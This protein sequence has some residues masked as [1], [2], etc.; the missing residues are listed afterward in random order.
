M[1]APA[2]G[3]GMRRFFAPSNLRPMPFQR[4]MLESM[5]K[6][7]AYRRIEKLRQTINHHRY[8]YHVEDREEISPAAL[9]SLKHELAE[10]EAEFP[11]LV[12]PDSPTQRVAGEPLPEFQKIRHAVRQWSFNDIFNEQELRDFDERM[13]RMLSEHFGKTVRPSYVCELKIDGL[14][15]V[16]TYEAGLLKTAATRGDGITGE[17]VTH[18]VRTIESVPLV[19]ERQ[20][21]CVVEG[22]VW[23]SKKEL[24]RI[25]G[26]REKTAEPPFANP[27][28]AAAGSIR[29]LDARI[30][31]SRKL[32]MFIYDL[33]AFEGVL[34]ETQH[35]ELAF[36]GELGFKTN[37]H[38]R[39]VASVDDIMAYWREWQKRAPRE[40]YLVDGIVIKVNERRFQEVLG[41]TGKAPRFAIA[42]KFPA[43]QVT[44][45]VRNIVLQ[46]GRTG[47]LTPVAELEPVSVAGSTVSRATLH[48]ED[49]IARLDVRVGDTVVLQKAGDVIPEIVS[50]VKELRTG[51]EKKFHFPK[52]VPE[53]GGDGAIERVPGEAAWRCK[54]KDSFAQI[55]RRFH[56]FVSK[57]ALNMDGLGPRI[58]DLLLERG[59]VREYADFFTLQ[60]GDLSGLPGFKEKAITN[61]LAGIH[62]A[63]HTTLPR[64]LVALSIDDIGE[65]TARDLARCFGTI[66]RL[67]A[68][69]EEDI[70]AIYG[71]GPIAAHSLHTW[72]HDAVHVL[73]LDHLL[74]HLFLAAETSASVS[75]TL[76]GKTFVLTGALSS[77]SRDEAKMR[78]RDAG[79]SVSE[80]VS[81]KTDYLVA[82]EAPGSKLAKAEALGVAVID[83]AML[84][85]LLLKA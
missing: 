82:G 56:H 26:E 66:E 47:I 31:A 76:A 18:N 84:L 54:A 38:A 64:L 51:R 81:K 3:V 13:V 14:K 80:S 43:E 44:T 27:R 83:E 50:V 34:P 46:I 20:V 77:L 33:A 67:R 59:L 25:N 78:I 22:E 45:R 48:N 28:N 1:S 63:A 29:Q 57:K 2:A 62:A 70:A 69:S 32:D 21:D 53:C 6:E 71:V 5:Q 10:L 12:T 19:L 73:I 41:Y 17:D 55:R 8:L 49:Q 4:G 23:L 58:V 15:I 79:G 24:A 72:F 74:P 35:G 11:D 75:G 37:P 42:F 52:Q 7:Q 60:A 85:A 16:L 68:A 30:A 39:E 36:L 9:D 65:E 61:V 40:E